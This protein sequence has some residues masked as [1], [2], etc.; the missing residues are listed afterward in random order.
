ADLYSRILAKNPNHADCLNLLGV[1]A[2]Q[3]GN[4]RQAA[5]LGEQAV[6][7]DATRPAYLVNLATAYRG[8]ARHEDACRCC[9]RALQTQPDLAEA[10]L[11]LGLSLKALKQS[12]EAEEQF[13]WLTDHRP[14]D[15]RGPQALANFLREQGRINEALASYCEALTRHPNDAAA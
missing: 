4:D 1:V 6:R 3:R 9:R 15:S 7:I 8:L 12:A 10:R 13:R 14:R 5:E 11:A 2:H